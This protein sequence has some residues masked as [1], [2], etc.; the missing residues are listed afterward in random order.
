MQQVYRERYNLRLHVSA[1][2]RVA[3][4]LFYVVVQQKS[5]CHIKLHIVKYSVAFGLYTIIHRY[6][7]EIRGEIL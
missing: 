6:E 7:N 3:S 2:K 5:T 4:R 1:H